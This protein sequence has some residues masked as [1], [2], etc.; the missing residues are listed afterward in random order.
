M[1]SIYNTYLCREPA[2]DVPILIRNG[3]DEYT[4]SL[5]TLQRSADYFGERDH[6]RAV[7]RLQ[8]EM[9]RVHMQNQQWE[10]A[11]QV[12]VP[13]W[14]ALSWRR[15]G[16]WQMLEEMDLALSECARH[17]K[18]YDILIGVEWEL[19]N[20]CELAG[21]QRRYPSDLLQL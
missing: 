18:D 7:E 6:T 20:N 19:S 17:V 2:G 11:T 4:A 14:Q 5:R 9:A 16:W 8:L 15:S 3:P 21:L 10:R 13:L 1:P 12:L